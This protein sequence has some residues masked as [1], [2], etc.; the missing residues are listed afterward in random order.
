MDGRCGRAGPGTVENATSGSISVLA[1][2]PS[3]IMRPK[4]GHQWVDSG[5]HQE[6]LSFLC[7][8]GEI[9]TP[10]PTSGW[11]APALLGT[12]CLEVL[13]SQLG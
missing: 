2:L 3:H 8:D 12:A 10:G 7:G 9:I 6:L 13:A 5:G 1:H 4:N 11:L